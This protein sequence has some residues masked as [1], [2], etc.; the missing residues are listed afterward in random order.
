MP[1]SQMVTGMHALSGTG[2]YVRGSHGVGVAVVAVTITS[3][4]NEGSGV[5]G[6]SVVE[7]VV[8]D[9]DAGPVS[10]SPIVSFHLHGYTV[11]VSFVF[12]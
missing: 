7:V 9:V 4:V 5:V 3:V 2:W 6:A 11:H 10:H 8:V 12:S 1:R